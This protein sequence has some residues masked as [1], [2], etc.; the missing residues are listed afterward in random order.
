MAYL[1]CSGKIKLFHSS[2]SHCFL[3]FFAIF[4]SANAFDG[5]SQ[6]LRHADCKAIVL[7]LT[8]KASKSEL[9]VL[10]EDSAIPRI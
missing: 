4:Q 9:F 6:L 3:Y 10:F 7:P 1:L 5:Y 2:H 8:I